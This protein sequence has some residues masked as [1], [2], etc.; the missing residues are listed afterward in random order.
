MSQSHFDPNEIND[1][2]VVT[3]A[4]LHNEAAPSA[5]WNQYR[6]EA[7]AT[8]KRLVLKGA[9]LTSG[10][11]LLSSLDLRDC[12]LWKCT[13]KDILLADEIRSAMNTVFYDSSFHKCA[14]SYA[15]PLIGLYPLD[16]YKCRLCDCDFHDSYLQLRLRH[17][18]VSDCDFSG[19]T[20][21]E[22]I[23]EDSQ[24][25]R[26]LFERAAL[27][28]FLVA[29]SKLIRCGFVQAA[30][31]GTGDEPGRFVD[32]QMSNRTNLH[33]ARL[34]NVEWDGG[35]LR[36]FSA[37]GGI[38]EHVRLR[39]VEIKRADFHRA[40][41]SYVDSENMIMQGTSLDGETSF[42]ESSSWQEALEI[43]AKVRIPNA[44]VKRVNF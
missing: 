19:V 33:Q 30:L 40:H 31:Q 4:Q 36:S 23:I 20:L 9:Q 10:S 1:A 5:C 25:S 13:L 11:R 16:L 37:T 38:W 44:A 43:A 17:S 32:T 2:L 7:N 27:H 34:A 41:F 35:S 6:E 18:S 42:F 22:L 29:R 3:A 28:G 15:P 8:G 26:I 39:D 24:L 21:P 14:I 12:V